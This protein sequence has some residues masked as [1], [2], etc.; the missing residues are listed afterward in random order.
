MSG[1]VTAMMSADVQSSNR[2]TAPASSGTVTARTS[3]GR[4]FE[5]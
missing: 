4:Y 1:T 2:M 5:K 3:C